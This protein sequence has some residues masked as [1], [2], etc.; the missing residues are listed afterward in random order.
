VQHQGHFRGQD[1]EDTRGCTQDYRML[2]E[3]SAG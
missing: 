3:G 1:R 2:R